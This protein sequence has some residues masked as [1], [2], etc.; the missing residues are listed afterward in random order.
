MNFLEERYERRATALMSPEIALDFWIESTWNIIGLYLNNSE[1]FTA[2]QAAHL[3]IDMILKTLGSTS[4]VLRDDWL[5]RH[6][7]YL[8]ED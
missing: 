5:Q 7:G 6:P 2:E 8:Q 1:Q 3:Y 4:M